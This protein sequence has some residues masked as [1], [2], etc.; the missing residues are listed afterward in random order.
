MAQE[1]TSFLV[2]LYTE[3]RASLHRGLGMFAK[4]LFA[5]F[6]SLVSADLAYCASPGGIRI[7]AWSGGP[8]HTGSRKQFEYCAATAANAQGMV[9]TYAVDGSYRWRLSFSNPTWSFS[10]GYALS[11]LLR[12]GDRILIP[13][14]ATVGTNQQLD[15]ETEDELQL[16][17]ALRSADKL[18]VTAGGL[19]LEFDLIGTSEVLAALFDCIRQRPARAETKNDKV[20]LTVDATARAEVRSLATSVM[21][22]SRIKDAQILSQTAGSWK[23]GL[24]TSALDVIRAPRARNMREFVP[25]LVSHEVGKCREGA[26]LIW[27][28]DAIDQSELLRAFLV[29]PGLD[30]TTFTYMAAA[31]RTQGGYFLLRSS[32]IGGGFA[33]VLQQQVADIDGR[34]RP[35]FMLAIKKVE[36]QS[37]SLQPLPPPDATPDART[38]EPSSES[39]NAAPTFTSP[40]GRY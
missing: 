3:S 37:Q 15:I 31:A 14:R 22:F 12:L 5:G 34:L 28:L 25:L 9:I 2:T 20:A 40:F 17:A 13:A 18:Q 30:G 33:G 11:V 7:G 10:E 36:Q 35:A 4:L 29:C 39:D 21:S 1:V 16:F 27:S 19:R 24:V 26:F 8:I 38:A 6:L 32:A 23:S